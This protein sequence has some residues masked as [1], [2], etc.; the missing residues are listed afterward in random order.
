MTMMVVV[1]PI[2]VLVSGSDE[3]DVDCRCMALDG[4]M[5]GKLMLEEIQYSIWTKKT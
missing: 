4:W 1:V 2:M 5:G 3:S